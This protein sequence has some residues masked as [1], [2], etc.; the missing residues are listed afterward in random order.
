M[1]LQSNVVAQRLCVNRKHGSSQ[2]VTSFVNNANGRKQ[3][4]L[5]KQI[6]DSTTNKLLMLQNNLFKS[7]TNC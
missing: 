3:K 7:L 4:S 1:Q 5:A 6:D 2:M